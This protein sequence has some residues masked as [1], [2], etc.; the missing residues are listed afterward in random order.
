[1]L[2]FR[3]AA[4]LFA[5]TL[6]STKAFCQSNASVVEK[7][8]REKIRVSP[9]QLDQVLNGNVP[10]WLAKE[11]SRKTSKGNNHTRAA[12]MIVSGS[13]DPESEV[14][15]AINP[16][17][18]ANIVV[19]ANSSAA[20]S[21]TN[22]LNPIYYT[23]NFG[24]TWELSPFLAKP[25][26]GSFILGGGDP[27][28]AFDKT[29]KV[30][31]SWINLHANLTTVNWD[32]FWAE[33]I[34]GGVSW[35]K[36]TQP[37][38]HGEGSLAT[39]TPDMIYDKQWMAVDR[40]NSAN[41]NTVY[42]VFFEA[43][44][45]GSIFQIG[46]RHKTAA[47]A[48]FTS[49]TV[50]ASDNGFTNLQ[51]SSIDVDNNGGVHVSYFATLDDQHWALYHALSTDGAATFGPST[52]ISD[53]YLQD[54]SYTPTA[55]SIVGIQRA[56]MYPCPHIR[57]DKTGSFAGRL[58][59]TWTAQGTDA[60]AGTGTDIYFNVSTDNGNT[61]SPAQRVN[62]DLGNADN[63]YPSIDVAANGVVVLTWYDRRDDP[64][65]LNTHYYMAYSFDGG[66]S[67]PNQYAVS[68]ASTDFSTVGSQTAGFG[69]GEYN[70]VVT[71]QNMAVPVWADARS[72]DGQLDVFAA[73]APLNPDYT[74]VQSLSTIGA[75]FNLGL[76]QPNPANDFIEVE[77]T[78]KNKS[79]LQ[80][81]VED[82][83]GKVWL[84]QK[85]N[86]N[87]KDKMRLN[88]SSL[89]AG[90]YTLR[91]TDGITQDTRKFVKQ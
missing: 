3:L 56:R 77:T 87:G 53:V 2:H 28:F 25:D 68:G 43:S 72:N 74:G 27:M 62:N 54:F 45:D 37:I 23:K 33:S 58:Y 55:D 26:G 82:V 16:N 42:C 80:L 51:F 65:N 5:A 36:G 52:K 17:D 47:A 40:S 1:M 24:N 78:S 38:A 20:S 91:A 41:Q 8:I 4:L 59:A 19:S 15:A 32:L 88:V 71:T 13:S 14:H 12:N 21:L 70:Q 86:V 44:G 81:K 66:A 22:G 18:S 39:F 69:V 49:T 73:I 83:T 60:D 79:T 63:F 31:M 7:I 64:S 75:A 6:F 35:T 10:A 9:E 29:G 11:E 61:W 34:D 85:W 30:Y 89:P 50:V 76:L 57:V 67:F 48:N 46:V 90:A 84:T